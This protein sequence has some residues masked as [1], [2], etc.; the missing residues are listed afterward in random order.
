MQL[1]IIASSRRHESR[2]AG[3][4]RDLL[5]LKQLVSWI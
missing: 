2:T 3:F 4:H 1:G 5:K